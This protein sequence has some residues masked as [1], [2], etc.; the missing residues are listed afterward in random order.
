MPDWLNIT[1]IILLLGACYACFIWGKHSGIENVVNLFL[2][3][4]IITEKDLEK[5]ND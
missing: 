1:E 3:K 4:K 5:L 2:E